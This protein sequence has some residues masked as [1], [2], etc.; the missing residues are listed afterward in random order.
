MRTCIS[1]CEEKV[2][3][4]RKGQ[5]ERKGV[6]SDAEVSTFVSKFSSGAARR[7]VLV[8][9]L[10]CSLEILKHFQVESE[11]FGAVFSYSPRACT[12]KIRLKDFQR[13]AVLI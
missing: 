8:L 3:L 12:E 9:A 6:R 5:G 1:R 2:T 10:P 11:D 13:K 4:G 7:A